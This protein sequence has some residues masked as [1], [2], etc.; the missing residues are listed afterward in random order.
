MHRICTYGL[1]ILFS[2]LP[3]HYGLAQSPPPS[4]LLNGKDNT[5]FSLVPTHDGQG[6]MMT[7]SVRDELSDIWSIEITRTDLD[8]N[9]E[10]SREVNFGDED[11]AFH[12]AA[13][14]FGYVITGHSQVA[15]QHHLLVLPIDGQGNLT[16]W[17]N[18]IFYRTDAYENSTGLY[19]EE[20]QDENL[21]VAG[22]TT[23][24][25]DEAASKES[26]V[27]KLN[28]QGNLL[29]H[30]QFD[31]PDDELTDFDMASNLLVL[32]DETIMV[33]GSANHYS[34]ATSPV[35]HQSILALL[36]ES[37]TGS[38]VRDQTFMTSTDFSTCLGG[39]VRSAGADLLYDPTL[40]EVVLLFNTTL[41]SIPGTAFRQWGMRSF[42]L[43]G[44][45]ITSQAIRR[46]GEIF[47]ALQI[48][49][50]RDNEEY[51]VHGLFNTQNNLT[52]ISSF[53][54]PIEA[55][56]LLPIGPMPLVVNNVNLDLDFLTFGGFFTPVIQELNGE[57]CDDIGIPQAAHAPLIFAPKAMARVGQ[58]TTILGYRTS[59]LSTNFDLEMTFLDAQLEGG[60]DR[61]MLP[62]NVGT[63]EPSQLEV[64][65]LLYEIDA[66][67]AQ[68]ELLPNPVSSVQCC[69]LL[70]QQGPNDGSFWPFHLT[71]PVSGLRS[72]TDIETGMCGETYLAGMYARE[73]LE[74]E[75]Q[76]GAQNNLTWTQG[77]T[78]RGI[79]IANLDA[80]GTL[81]W[82]IEGIYDVTND[83]SNGTGRYR[84]YPNAVIDRNLPNLFLDLDENGN[85]Y[86][87]MPK[88][89][90][91]DLTFPNNATLNL[92]GTPDAGIFM[93]QVSAATG[94]LGWNSLYDFLGTHERI[95]DLG[96]SDGHIYFV[97][98]GLGWQGEYFMADA[99]AATGA[100]VNTAVIGAATNMAPSLDAVNGE[101][102]YS[103]DHQIGLRDGNLNLIWVQN[104]LP[105]EVD[106][107]P[108]PNS[109]GYS[110][111]EFGGNQQVFAIEGDGVS[112]F[113]AANGA[114]QWHSTQSDLKDLDAYEQGVTGVRTTGTFL[115]N[116]I[117][118]HVFSLPATGGA[119]FW[120]L[121]ISGDV[122]GL[123]RPQV[124]TNGF[125]TY[126]SG[127]YGFQSSL[128]TVNIGTTTLT[129]PNNLSSWNSFVS[130][131]QLVGGSYF[132][133]SPLVTEL[134]PELLVYPNPSQGK[135]I[136]NLEERGVSI[137]EPVQLSVFDLNGEQLL[138]QTWEQPTQQ[139]KLNLSG[140][141]K[142]I[143]FLQ[144]QTS[145]W[146]QH[147]KVIIR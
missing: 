30:K 134:A 34:P 2:I 11:R 120:D 63:N 93:M 21:L 145:S 10:W 98:E 68:V 91:L 86:F 56:Q 46:T 52:G 121:T 4:T 136:V 73:D 36:L 100:L 79:F 9:V 24:A 14:S 23:A 60:C 146:Q 89:G 72:V 122:T 38:V 99:L 131:V 77:N 32:P 44:T 133:Q 25:Y 5:G 70:T 141:A 125:A 45:P 116:P 58:N 48:E 18:P 71:G 94:N 95:G 109:F 110:D 59:S 33:T 85:L 107:G 114:L 108:A 64:S 144:A 124:S 112:A 132:R 49:L 137:T 53:V 3:F 17:M 40:E 6:Y 96:V 82:M 142:G 81:I 119:P 39:A 37:N 20:D 12:I 111:I 61:S 1:W 57:I 103:I 83:I 75:N 87:G 126:F 80:S 51:L 31:S 117:D 115:G 62:V 88:L 74:L 97:G 113:N 76:N 118:L 127:Q 128:H 22:F 55:G 66:L 28:T 16:H 101:I 140:L 67:P 90:T 27:L 15:G 129:T 123:V 13:T 69:D 19:I 138:T 106:G 105:P 54:M 41:M 29:W 50:G 43:G 135:I 78:E 147:Q 8:G 84:E 35:N 104:I 143:Y 42:Q 7:G 130:R 26:I 139:M 65:E 102:Y 92:A 47:A